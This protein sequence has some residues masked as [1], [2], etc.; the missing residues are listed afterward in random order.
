[1]FHSPNL[2]HLFPDGLGEGEVLLLDVFHGH[3]FAITVGKKT[4]Q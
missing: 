1:M 3:G 2:F 4:Q